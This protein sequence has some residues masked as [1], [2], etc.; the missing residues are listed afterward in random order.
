MNQLMQYIINAILMASLVLAYPQE[1]NEKVGE[2]E[3]EN[4]IENTES[5]IWYKRW[6]VMGSA[7]L[8]LVALIVLVVF[9]IKK[10]KAGI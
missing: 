8:G 3:V 4:K 2:T 9:I 5:P 7:A 1:T 6:D 10:M